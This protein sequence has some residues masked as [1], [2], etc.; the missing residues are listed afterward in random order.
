IVPI[1]AVGGEPVDLP[2]GDA[3]VLARFEDRLQREGELR[4]RRPPVLVVRGLADADD[5]DPAPDASRCRHADLPAGPGRA[6]SAQAARVTCPDPAREQYRGARA[7]SRP[8]AAGR[9]QRGEPGPMG[10]KGACTRVHGTSRRVSSRSRGGSS[11]TRST[12]SGGS[13]ATST[14]TYQ[15]APTWSGRPGAS[16]SPGGSSRMSSRPAR[17]T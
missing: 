10:T 17:M 9:G 5:R 12:A 13:D 2:R 1:V 7:L 6:A 16:A 4:V 14:V 8:G 11:G 3:R 15:P